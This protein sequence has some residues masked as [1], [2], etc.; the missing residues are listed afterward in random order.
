MVY[1][2][3]NRK[4]MVRMLRKLLGPTATI[5]EAADGTEAV[6]LCAQLFS[7][8]NNASDPM[9][10]GSRKICQDTSL[11]ESSAAGSP[12]ATTT[13]KAGS[14]S[15]IDPSSSVG[16][17]G[18]SCLDMNSNTLPT[19]PRSRSPS[20]PTTSR[21]TCILQHPHPSNTS[22]SNPR[23]QPFSVIFMDIIMPIMDGYTASR[24]IRELGISTPIVVTT[25]NM[26]DE[27]QSSELGVVE[28]IQK[29]FTKEKITGVLQ[30]VGVL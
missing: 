27:E 1:E 13:A 16:G 17:Q 26:V 12:A 9:D 10:T 8:K 23:P 30:K 28:A 7:S 18:R 21:P 15:T 4:I 2:P 20:H 24:H 19:P 11:N 14:E 5:H 29:P 25:A 3:I 6:D 22:P